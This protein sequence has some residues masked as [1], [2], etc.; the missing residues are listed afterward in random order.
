MF[1]L[2]PRLAVVVMLKLQQAKVKSEFTENATFW[3]PI[4]QIGQTI[5]WE[6]GVQVSFHKLK[7]NAIWNGIKFIY[8]N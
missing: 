1:L 2:T 3:P 6:T 5:C 8:A 4:N 7:V